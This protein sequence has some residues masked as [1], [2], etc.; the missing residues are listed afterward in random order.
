MQSTTISNEAEPCGSSPSPSGPS[1]SYNPPLCSRCH[2]ENKGGGEEGKMMLMASELR[3]GQDS[4]YKLLR[5]LR[6]HQAADGND[7]APSRETL[8]SV[9]KE[10]EDSISTCIS[11][12]INTTTSTGPSTPAAIRDAIDQRHETGKLEDSGESSLAPAAT[13][14][15]RGC[16][17]KR[18][19]SCETWIKDSPNQMADEHAWRKY[20][21]KAILNATHP[22]YIYTP[23]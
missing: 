16:Y 15:R 5:L 1:A 9:A 18:R 12:S 11:L 13:K 23:K 6:P 4:T 21:Q 19:S 2:D 8:A 17:K 22:R 10:I 20:G 14:G 7:S 3:K